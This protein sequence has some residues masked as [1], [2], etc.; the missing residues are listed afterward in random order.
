[1]STSVRTATSV[2]LCHIIVTV[3]STAST[4]QMNKNVVSSG[5]NYYYMY[6]L[7]VNRYKMLAL[8]IA[9]MDLD[10]SCLISASIF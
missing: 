10:S 6:S 5:V 7:H 3:K 1:M 9:F 8:F 2:F 4:S